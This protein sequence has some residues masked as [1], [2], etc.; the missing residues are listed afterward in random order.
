MVAGINQKGGGGLEERCANCSRKFATGAS[1]DSPWV[2]PIQS[3]ASESTTPSAVVVLPKTPVSTESMDPSLLMLP[4]S[5]ISWTSEDPTPSP[6]ERTTKGREKKTT[7]S[8]VRSQ[9]SQSHGTKHV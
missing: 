5:L 2:P 4:P 1:V 6:G 7:C 9:R 3:V 8:K